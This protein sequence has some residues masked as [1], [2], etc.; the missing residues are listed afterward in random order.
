MNY[1]PADLLRLYLFGTTTPSADYND[2]IRSSGQPAKGQGLPF[3]FSAVDY[4]MNGGGRYAYPALFPLVSKFFTQNIPDNTYTLQEMKALLG[5]NKPDYNIGILQY[6]T[7]KLTA[8]YGERGL[9]FGGN[10]YELMNGTFK[11]E[12]GVK[13]IV[14]LEVKAENED[15]DFFSD[16][17]GINLVNWVLSTFFLDPYS[18]GK[19]VELIY[20]GPGQVHSTI[21]AADFAVQQQL[22]SGVVLDGEYVRA[23]AGLPA[24]LLNPSTGFFNSLRSTQFNNFLKD[25]LNVIYG[26]VNSDSLDSHSNKG[27]G[28][29]GPRMYFV[30][31]PG[32]DVIQVGTYGD[33][34]V[35]GTGEDQLKG[36]VRADR[37][38]GE[39]DNDTL[40]G[41]AGADYL[42]GGP[43]DDRLTGG[44]GADT[45]VGGAGFDTYVILTFDKDEIR[46]SDAQ[47]KVLDDTT[48][49]I[50]GQKIANTPNVWQDAEK[51]YLFTL[52]P[53]ASGNDLVITKL[54][55]PGGQTA[56]GTATVR[57]FHSG[58]L[59]IVLSGD[60]VAGPVSVN[61]IAGGFIKKLKDDNKT[62]E[63]SEFG[64][65]SN[66]PDPA[67]QDILWGT[68]FNDT[69]TAG[70][71]N[72]GLDGGAFDDV[73]DGGN[74]ADL[75]LGGLGWDAMFGG[76][77]DDF[78]FGSASG[79]RRLLTTE[80][81]P[82]QA[83]GPELARGWSWVI[84]TSPPD[85][86]GRNVITVDGA[87]I[88][89]TA[90]DQ[91]NSID[92]GAGNDHVAAGTGGDEVY[93]GDGD[94]QISGMAGSDI[95][96]G[97]AGNDKLFG[98]GVN[99]DRY[100]EFAPPDTHAGDILIGGA[101]DDQLVG[102]GGGDELYGG[103]GADAL[104]GDEQ[105]KGMIDDTPATY[106]GNDY[107]D[108]GEGNDYLEGGGKDDILFGGEGDDMIWGDSDTLLLA[109]AFHGEDY[110]DGESGNDALIGG[111]GRD[112][113]Y[114]GDG[115]DQL[116]G[117]DGAASLDAQFHGA[118]Y[119][120]GEAGD[121]SLYG[122]G[123]D[124]V[125]LGG[126]GN[127]FLSGEDQS[128]YEAA[129]VL[130]G[131]DNLDGGAGNDTLLG[132]PGD[133]VL[134]GGDGNDV[135]VGGSGTNMMSGGAGNDV[136]ISTSLTDVIMED[137]DGGTD[138]VQG[139]VGMTLP[140]NIENLMLTGAGDLNAT[141]NDGANFLK[142]NAGNNVLVGAGGADSLEGGDGNDTLIG[143]SSATGEEG[144]QVGGSA[145]AGDY[146]KGG[147]GDDSYQESLVLPQHGQ[148]PAVDDHDGHDQLIIPGAS[149]ANLAATY[150]S[151]FV[152]LS[153]SSG[154]RLL[155]VNGLES[156]VAT[157]IADD[158]QKS[159]PRL[160]AERLLTALTA[161]S[162]GDARLLL[163]GAASD[164]LTI[165]TEDAGVAVSPGRAN[166]HIAIQ[167]ADGATILF[168]AGDGLD[169]IT[170]VARTPANAQT[171]SPAAK[172]VL[173]LDAGLTA[174]DIQLRGYG[175]G[176]FRLAVG[177]DEGFAFAAQEDA[178]TNKPI[179]G[180]A[181]FDEI[182]FAGGQVLSW[183]E[184]LNTH[185]ARILPLGT[186]DSDTIN[187]SNASEQ[188]Y[189]LGGNDTIMA[190]GGNDF[191]DGGDGIDT[192]YGGSG[193][194]TLIHAE[195]MYG[196]DGNDTYIV[197]SLDASVEVWDVGGNDSEHDVL[198]LPAGWTPQNVVVTHSSTGDFTLKGPTGYN[199]I[200][201]RA[202]DSALQSYAAIEE[203]RFSDGSMW[204]PAQLLARD[205]TDDTS[206]NRDDVTGHMWGETLDGGAGDDKLSGVGVDDILIGGAGR[207]LLVGGSGSDNYR[208]GPGSGDD[209]VQEQSGS[210]GELDWIEVDA[211]PGQTSVFRNGRD[212]VVKIAG[213]DS[214]LHISGY[215]ASQS[216]GHAATGLSIEGLRFPDTT[217]WMEADVLS[218]LPSTSVDAFSG[219]TSG[220]TFL[221][222]DARDTVTEASGGGIDLVR[223]TVS[224]VLPENI[225]NLTATGLLD[226]T[227]QGNSLDNVITGNAGDNVLNGMGVAWWDSTAVSTWG[228]ADTLIGGAGNDVY[229]VDGSVYGPHARGSYRQDDIVVE[230]PGEGI[231]T[232]VFQ[233]GNGD[234][235]V[236]PENVEILIAVAPGTLVGNALDNIIE[237]RWFGLG[238]LESTIDGGAGADWMIGT[239]RPDTYFVDN[240]GDVV[241][242]RSFWTDGTENTSYRD[243]VKSTISYTLPQYI[244]DLVL[245]GSNP[246]SGT[247]NAAGNYL[248]GY[249]NTAANA[250][251]GGAGDDSYR[252]GPNDTAVELAGAGRD[253]LVFAWTGAQTVDVSGFANFERFALDPSMADSN[254]SAATLTAPVELVGNSFGH[255]VLTGGAGDDTIYDSD[256]VSWVFNGYDTLIGGA[257]KDTLVSYDRTDLLDGGTGDDLLVNGGMVKFGRG[258]GTDIA[259]INFAQTG[260]YVLPFRVMLAADISLGDLLLQQD[261]VDLIV[262]VRGT[263]DTMRVLR[264]F[265][266]ETTTMPRSMS[267]Q[268][269]DGLGLD[270]T[271]IQSLLVGG[272]QALPTPGDDLLI[273]TDSGESINGLAGN[274]LIAGAGGDDN[275]FGGEGW[276][277]LY[278]GS[279][280][281]VLDGGVSQDRLVG[282]PGNDSYLVDH[283]DD[284]IVEAT[285]EGLDSVVSTSNYTL[286]EN[287]ETLILSG[288]NALMG[289]G[290]GQNNSMSGNAQANQLD[291]GGGADL[292]TGGQGN[293]SYVVDNAGDQTIEAAG[294][295]T[296][297]VYSSISWTLGGNVENLT[298]TGSDD[299]SATGNELAN[300]LTGNDGA[301]VLDGGLGND[302][303]SGGLGNDTYIVDSNG[304]VIT[305]S[306]NAGTDTVQAS[307][308]WTL[309]ANFEKLTLIGTAGIT[310]TGNTLNNVLQGNAGNNTLSGGTGA[311]AM[312]GGAGD[313]IYV[314]DNAGDSVAENAGEGT[315]TVQSS[316]A[317]TLAANVENLTLTGS[318]GIA[319]T[320]NGLD[321]VMTGNGGNNT[322]SGG[323]GNDL[324]DGGAGTDTLVGG[325]GDDIYVVNVSGDVVTEAIGEGS[326]TIQS[327]I[328]WTLGTNVENLVLTG[329]T[330]TN[331]TGNG[332]DNSLTGNSAA[333]VLDGGSGSDAIAGGGGND[334]YY[335]DSALDV[336]TE[337]AG[338]G[339]D[340][341]MASVTY[342]LGTELE[343]LTLIGSAAISAYGNAGANTLTGNGG[344][345]TLDG[346]AG[347][348]TM[349]GGGGDDTYVVD[350]ASD[351]IT[352]AASA[353]TDTVTSNIAWTLGSN[354]EN[355]T[356]LGTTAING[357]GNTLSNVLRGNTGNNTLDGGSGTDTLIGGAGNDTYVVDVA[358]D[359]ITELPNEGTDLVQAAVT[360]T[361]TAE[362]ENLTLT[363]SSAINGT[364]NGLDNVLTGNSGKNTLSGGAGNDWIDG[365]AGIDTMSGGTGDD[366]FVVDVSTDVVTENSGEGTDRVQSAVTWTLGNNL[367]NLTLTGTT[368][369]NGTG[370]ALDNVLIG[371]S[372]V[373]TL[374][375]AG[376]ND[377]L[378]G[379]AGNDTLVGG[380]GNDIYIV[381]STSDVTTEAANEGT[382]TVQS[383]VTWTLGTN[384]ENLT[385]TGSAAINGTGHAGNNVLLGNAGANTL[386][387]AAGNDTLDG[388]A[389]NDL[390]VGGAN[391]D[392]YVFGRTY[393]ADTIQENDT[394]A[395]VVDIV[396]F[397][398]GIV[399]TDIAFTKVGNDLQ[400][401]IIGT[402]DKLVVKDW[403]LGSAYH[404]EQ[405]KFTNGTVLTDAQVQGL[406]PPL[407]AGNMD[408][409]LVGLSASEAW[410]I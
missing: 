95:L 312:S 370:N 287:V 340:I 335:V 192:V 310:A 410:A 256:V 108:A 186:P 64:Y 42:D 49:I 99:D 187:A 263:S 45:L 34:A 164:A 392:T 299:V 31:G 111:G 86:A 305:E 360:W 386:S 117:D 202:A 18:M 13:T 83:D 7:D 157:V 110:L 272:G 395:G 382:D 147:A 105:R 4:M 390:L 62:Y 159:Y 243:T 383:S 8:D 35:G 225:E 406:V 180:T 405:F 399:Q 149:I 325:Q 273:G 391:A 81:P 32:N 260:S 319:G 357:T 356:L 393:G 322:L 227:L 321:N 362:L 281:D 82:P 55:A 194:D 131:N 3:E 139:L 182:R 300:V 309:G 379:G 290:N 9:I 214:E 345:N 377:T 73:M 221:V 189:G 6:G 169:E 242:D 144:A 223:T 232:V 150:S 140:A 100:A 268:L 365:G 63:T 44:D 373:N 16:T 297:L 363:G 275:L 101:G 93:G 403:Y 58:D 39:A 220:D 61:N 89:A 258:Y 358:G 354:L 178:A 324:L 210:T 1:N 364:G 293:D 143:G 339:T 151:G 211:L 201:L 361:L 409:A 283:I 148:A 78:I 136:Y 145:A 398:S 396:T 326:D 254:L 334:T 296:D 179:D 387:G 75:M 234:S 155:L 253:S 91:G 191:V 315:D 301:N 133:D 213:S 347:A 54:V 229:Y 67:S 327:A 274:D 295:G 41:A 129:T 332:L 209:T 271:L 344:A 269:A 380:A 238:L 318:S 230:N 50:G 48:Q 313:D 204:N 311:D 173:V 120:D 257:G 277:F 196:D 14:G 292:M 11:V 228:G 207:D 267:I 85:A 74:G 28:S 130:T 30:G 224:Y 153:N 68:D 167:S 298:L 241:D 401:A 286:S 5:S 125:L 279:G 40:E 71:G 200:V 378:D 203:I 24:Y 175:G 359:T 119:L 43:G 72:D 400:A 113:L 88:H 376:G 190:N 47:G 134:L 197:E 247:G 116:Q 323:A 265:T 59:G 138:T 385:L 251:A 165:R 222:D 216:S 369:I 137:L 57:D 17:P 239:S 128:S 98:D 166:D 97:D 371:N 236:L 217:V 317:W 333:N 336:V 161:S 246:I 90:G 104:Y 76:D 288:V 33:T 188:I 346:G 12:G 10:H 60:T 114:G 146:L 183:Q 23:A 46:D 338:G 289:N 141:G 303:M 384:L 25:G 206:A 122:D 126:D 198:V 52:V 351:V 249:V 291:G 2:H 26:T 37:L 106:H 152:Q 124:D 215:F 389:G 329:N 366:V 302:S 193:N 174:S 199:T 408:I 181:P 372:A 235:A 79:L 262:G 316:L 375:G 240:P 127:D 21:T 185:F 168:T 219:T 328:T 107:L 80:A 285:G 66:G 115:N 56:V 172:N 308:S 282:G 252:I 69:L 314:V 22:G 342:T 38:Y 96:F 397:G 280:N 208:F 123:G 121:D 65:V 77:G 394:T 255:N 233:P 218:R 109:G 162:G 205:L 250:L 307:V 36:G 20:T 278:G 404:V 154:A 176:E 330:A 142:G 374:T 306:S 276:D 163:G 352:E 158:G 177:P 407:F 118:D 27:P 135:L 348:D 170:A 320:G 84:Y 160:I 343:N 15:F 368:A 195:K 184:V 337:L 112:E 331:G 284:V 266:S 231:D 248:D 171:G 349:A 367:E 29:N 103:I 92:A 341:V 102:Q 51:K 244:E 245:I 355:L 388:G 353:G 70:N 350:S 294:E 156:S 259:D 264:A 237:T 94:D 261:G 304:D 381:D 402:S 132:G 226:V 270:A 87:N 212:L 53:V 19:T